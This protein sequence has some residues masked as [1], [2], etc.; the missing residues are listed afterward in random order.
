[1]RISQIR[2]YFNDYNE[3]AGHADFVGENVSGAI[4][5]SHELTVRVLEL[6]AHE[7]QQSMYALPNFGIE[8][9]VENSLKIA[10]SNVGSAILPE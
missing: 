5:L 3:I 4:K 6:A 9:V 10:G 7:L 1:M 2:F 8:N